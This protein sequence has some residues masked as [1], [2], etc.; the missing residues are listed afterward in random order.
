MGIR[1]GMQCQDGDIRQVGKPLR[2]LLRH[3]IIVRQIEELLGGV[4]PSPQLQHGAF[5]GTRHG[6]HQHGLA[7]TDRRLE[8]VSELF[9]DNDARSGRRA[10][11]GEGGGGGEG[12]LSAPGRPVGAGGAAAAASAELVE[13]VELAQPRPQNGP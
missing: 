5:A 2:H 4:P 9:G 13:L 7:G 12:H 1:K 11:G 6:S 3:R 8:N 10:G